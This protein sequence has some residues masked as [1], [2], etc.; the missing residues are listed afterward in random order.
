MNKDQHER[1]IRLANIHIG[2]ICICARAD[3]VGAIG[4]VLPGG[5]YTQNRREALN[6][7]RA[8][9]FIADGVEYPMPETTKDHQ[10]FV[11]RK[12]AL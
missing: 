1:R 8:M 12:G 6:A 4:W 5:G 3:E 2:S 11:N 9:A 7:A 10:G